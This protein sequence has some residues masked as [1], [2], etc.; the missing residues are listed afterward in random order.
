MTKKN[1]LNRQPIHYA[2]IKGDIKKVNQLMKEKGFK[3][4]VKDIDGF[5]P[6]MFAC[7]HGHLNIFN[8]LLKVKGVNINMRTYNGKT[9]LMLAAQK[10]HIKIVNK[11]LSLGAKTQFKE[12]K[13]TKR[14]CRTRTAYNMARMCGHN[15]IVKKLSKK[16]N[17]KVQKAKK[18][19]ISNKQKGGSTTG[20]CDTL[21]N[22]WECINPGCTDKG[23]G[24][25]KTAL[26]GSNYFNAIINSAG[27]YPM[28]DISLKEIDLNQFLEKI[29]LKEVMLNFLLLKLEIEKSILTINYSTVGGKEIN[30]IIKLNI[31]KSVLPDEIKSA[32]LLGKITRK[33]AKKMA[34]SITVWVLG[35]EDITID[36]KISIPKIQIYNKSDDTMVENI[37]VIKISLTMGLK[38]QGIITI[39]RSVALSRIIALSSKVENLKVAA[40]P[41]ESLGVPY[42]TKMYNTI[43]SKITNEDITDNIFIIIGIFLNDPH[44]EIAKNSVHEYETE[45]ENYTANY[46]KKILIELYILYNPDKINTLQV[47]YYTFDK[48][49]Q[50]IKVGKGDLNLLYD[51]CK[52]DVIER[53]VEYSFTIDEDGSSMGGVTLKI[54]EAKKLTIDDFV[55]SFKGQLI[56]NSNPRVEDYEISFYYDTGGDY[57]SQDIS[58]LYPV[59]ELVFKLYNNFINSTISA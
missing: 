38:I 10:G 3:L 5:T 14:S 49:Y 6:I 52:T 4:N 24:V 34:R 21:Q 35:Q 7:H 12:R 2:C 15:N 1:P 53:K 54:G 13:R 47:S 25:L 44:Y 41:L 11:L 43:K 58:S 46:Y 56:D 17:S 23:I 18:K 9:C 45:T 48:L 50:M 19:V 29:K 31:R 32:S 59:L 27:E 40:K 42:Y 57:L 28:F 33:I 30:F 8:K 16:K 36:F 22:C 39:F 51:F 55:K 37:S 26:E 20:S